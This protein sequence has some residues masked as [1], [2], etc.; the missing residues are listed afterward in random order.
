APRLERYGVT[1]GVQNHCDRCMANAMQLRYLI[2][3]YNPKQIA[4][5][6]DAAHNALQ[7]EDPDLA[8]DIVW[9]HLCMV[10]LKNAYWRRI[11]GPE[12]DVA[13]WQHYWT[14]GRQGL[15]NWPRI[16]AELRQRGY[17]GVI[18]LTAEYSD[19]QAVDR[20]ISEDIAFARALFTASGS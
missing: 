9:S 20:L 8:L 7:G 17:A 2:G 6:W 5:V 4:A 16:A 11:N 12:A 3:Q 18:C 19:E 14:S 13:R 15:A 1:L 10:N